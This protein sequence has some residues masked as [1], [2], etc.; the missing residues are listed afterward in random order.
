MKTL[1]NKKVSFIILFFLLSPL[2][3]RGAA[4]IKQLKGNAF[5]TL[6]GKTQS[7][8]TGDHIPVGAE[9]LTEEGTELT[10]ANYFN[11]QFH[12]TGSCHLQVGKKSTVLMEGYLWFRS[13]SG[14]R[15]RNLDFNIKTANGIVQ[16]N[17]SEGIISF[18]PSSGK[19]QFLSFR[20]N[21]LFFNKVRPGPQYE[22]KS[23]MFSFIDNNH[24]RGLPRQP[25]SLGLKPYKKL[26]ALFEGIRPLPPIPGLREQMNSRG[27]AS[28]EDSGGNS[29]QNI[30]KKYTL[31]Q[32]TRPQKSGPAP[33]KFNIY[34]PSNTQS[35][36]IKEESPETLIKI[37]T[38][39]KRQ[40]SKNNGGRAPASVPSL[41]SSNPFEQALQSR[42]KEKV[43][44]KKEVNSLIDALKS[45]GQD[46][47]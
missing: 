34:A 25:I 4:V 32:N 40:T 11:H 36:E 7:L 27:I 13:V 28:I 8:H 21:N 29:L 47:Q 35:T 10:L 41:E 19:T 38:K 2:V 33:I 3:A 31:Q 12:I 44:Q 6:D 16:Y 18:D 37:G 46:Y 39:N 30:L 5:M 24:N 14:S 20:G 17:D 22:V 26:M 43:N 45:I 23:S 42:Y 9:V 15:S 1:F